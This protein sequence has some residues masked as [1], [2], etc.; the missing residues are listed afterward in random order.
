MPINVVC[1]G[2]KKR[3][4]VNEKFAGQKG[5][6]PS[7][8]AI[9]QIPEK[10]ED[11]V[12]HA[13]EAAGPKDTKGTAVIKPILREETR[14]DPRVAGGIAAAVL[15]TFIVAW[16]VGASFKPAQK[17]QSA[18]IPLPF[19][20][21]A[22]CVLGPLLA[23]G[24]Y[25]FLRNDELEP[26]RGKEMWLRVGACGLIYAALWGVYAMVPWA[27]GMTRGFDTVELV[28]VVPPFIALGAFAAF[29]SLD[30]EFL[31]GAIHY[32]LYLLVTVLLRIAAHLNA[33]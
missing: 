19:K 23:F 21:L 15:V 13:P 26:F 1:P 25:T 28:Y 27:L 7:C 14:F 18:A 2:C 8:K 22:A 5:P 29:A 3:F 6:C 11:V 20:A 9:I 12:I 30:L 32:G 16:I 31:T 24:G 4:A 17:G 10:Q 33:F